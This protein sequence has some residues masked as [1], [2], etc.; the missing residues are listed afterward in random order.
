MADCAFCRL[1]GD[2][3]FAAIHRDDDVMAFDDLN[4]QAPVHFLVI[5]RQHI[6]TI[7]GV[8]N[9]HL[10]GSM[11]EVANR[12]ARDRAVFDSGYRLV[13]NSGPDAGQTVH[14]VHLHVLGGRKLTWPP[15]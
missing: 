6:E 10:L 4:P 2:P 5:P 11:F 14:H 13:L 3:D 12:V 7:A 1:A 9:D 15:G 8:T